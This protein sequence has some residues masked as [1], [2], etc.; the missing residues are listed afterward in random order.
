[1]DRRRGGTVK[2]A[3][4]PAAD[5][6]ALARAI[7]NVTVNLLHSIEHLYGVARDCMGQESATVEPWVQARREELMSDRRE[8]AR[9]L[10]R[11]H[12][13]PRLANS[14]RPRAEAN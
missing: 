8:T 5:A 12:Q 14:A 9:I 6:L 11:T 3:G 1:M 13:T 10:N 4:S 7:G 2:A